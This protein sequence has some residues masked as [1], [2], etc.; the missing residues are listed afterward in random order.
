MQPVVVPNAARRVPGRK[1]N[2]YRLVDRSSY[3]KLTVPVNAKRFP[4]SNFRCNQERYRL[5]RLTGF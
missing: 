4:I 5:R 1:Q 2:G 3:I